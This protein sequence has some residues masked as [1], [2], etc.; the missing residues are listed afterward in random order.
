M[1]KMI[2]KLSDFE[3]EEKEILMEMLANHMK[4]SFLAWNKDAVEDE[5]I[6]VAGFYPGALFGQRQ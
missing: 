2:Q 4:K 5:K 6:F 1:E 3:G